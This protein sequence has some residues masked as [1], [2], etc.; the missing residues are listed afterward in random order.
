MKTG[1]IHYEHTK[2]TQIFHEIMSSA[3]INR[4]YVK[5]YVK[6]LKIQRGYHNMTS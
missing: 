1:I 2:H 6:C 4:K 3:N 5:I